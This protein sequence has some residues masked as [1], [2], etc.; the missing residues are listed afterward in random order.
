MMSR[1]PLR[2]P[3][4][5]GDGG[6]PGVGVPEEVELLQ[7]EAIYHRLQV[8]EPGLQREVQGAPFRQAGARPS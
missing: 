5:E 3:G 7:A 4:R 1:Y 2:V 6:R 8:E